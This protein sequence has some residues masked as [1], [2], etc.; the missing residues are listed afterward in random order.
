MTL[1]RRD[2]WIALGLFLL[3]L[4]LRWPLRGAAVEE[5]DSVN[6]AGAVQKFDLENHYPHPSGYIFLIW[7]ARL[8][9]PFTQDP[10]RALSSLA[11]LAGACAHALLYLLARRFLGPLAAV[12]AALATIF[13][14][15]IWFQQ[16]RPMSDAYA[17]L[18]QVAVVWLIVRAW[19]RAGWPWLAAMFAFGAAA[20][21][22]QLLWFFLSGLLVHAVVDRGRRRGAGDALRGGIAFAAGVLAWFVPLSILC[23]GP[24][25]YVA[26]VNEEVAM[27]QPRE[28]I[29][30]NTPGMLHQQAAAAFD[31]VWLH[32]PWP[33]V[34]W[35]LALVGAAV[36][37]WRGPRWLVS[38]TLPAVLVRFALL[39]Y[40]PRFS[41]Y[42][43]P[44][45]LLL[46]VLGFHTLAERAGRRRGIVAAAG[47][48][49]LAAWSNAQA[50]AILPT[51]SAFHRAVAPVES[52]LRYARDR[53]DPEETLVISD[54]AL[55]G[56]HAE[57]Y[58]PR[59]GLRYAEEAELQPA[60]IKAARHILKLQPDWVARADSSWSDVTPLGTWFQDI[61]RWRDLSP[62]AGAWQA[63][64]FELRGA[65]AVFR[66]WRKETDAR[67]ATVRY[68]RPTGSNITVLHAPAS[69]F[70]L[71]LRLAPAPAPGAAYEA[72][73]VINGERRIAWRGTSDAIVRVSPAESSPRAFIELFS[74]CGADGRCFPVTGYEVTAAPSDGAS[75]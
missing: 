69:G 60:Q 1:P 16:V 44:F 40:W 70:E 31:L 10:I 42:Y 72:D 75:S 8:L 4:A 21:A 2:L 47:L 26:W 62:A 19:D 13:C 45:V 25:A 11:A 33:W 39:G 48:L 61:P 41:I 58:A 65:L 54:Y 27:Q 67:G 68:P 43:A 32:G 20:G 36:A 34:I 46:A 74:R 29:F 9:Q 50:R 64:L 56:R 18:W 63:S 53:Y 37:A 66:N 28:T 17:S 3:T 38:A 49:L 15:Q 55:L 7:T 57:Y 59:L 35:P 51:L 14:G 6:Y 22:K 30:V 73:I 71:R 12:A 5:F 52:A 23:G 24:R